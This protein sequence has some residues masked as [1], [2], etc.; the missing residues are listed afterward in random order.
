M[1]TGF[2]ES[3]VNQVVSKRFCNEQQVPWNPARHASAVVHRRVG[4]FGHSSREVPEVLEDFLA[5]AI[6]RGAYLQYV[7]QHA[8]TINGMSFLVGQGDDIL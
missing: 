8:N 7:A 1:S 3:T 4:I 5:N 6:D 2:V